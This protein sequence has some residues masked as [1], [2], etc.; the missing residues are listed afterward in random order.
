MKK[1]GTLTK[2]E[3]QI[4]NTLW[5]LPSQKGTI[6]ELLERFKDKKPAYTTVA[7]FMKILL[8]KSYVGF[9]K[10][11]GTKTLCYYPLISK[12]QYS[13]LVLSEVKND[14]FG[15]SFSSLV[16]FFIKEEEISEE[17]LKELLDIVEHQKI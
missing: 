16:R 10:M 15:G 13:R 7:T 6:N 17:E 4:M 5:S 12:A 11:K 3:M 2:A 9:E 8:N 14:L 1:Q